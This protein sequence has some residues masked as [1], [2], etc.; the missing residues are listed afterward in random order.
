MLKCI[1]NV[2]VA[3]EIYV[4]LR[5]YCLKYI[6]NVVF[7]LL[8]IYLIE[9]SKFSMTYTSMYCY[10]PL[11]YR[12]ARKVQHFCQGVYEQIRCTTFDASY[13]P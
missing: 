12:A 11:L 3:K 2:V 8:K 9:N 6:L 1:I 5:K 13:P 4:L 10:L 7:K